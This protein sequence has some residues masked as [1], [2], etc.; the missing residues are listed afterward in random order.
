MVLKEFDY[1]E[2][3]RVRNTAILLLKPYI[4][5]LSTNEALLIFKMIEPRDGIASG[6]IVS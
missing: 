2:K 6:I 3:D 1:P 4:A 5:P